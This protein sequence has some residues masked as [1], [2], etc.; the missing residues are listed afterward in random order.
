[1]G[2]GL[3]RAPLVSVLMPV[4]Q[5]ERH[6]AE[7]VASI[8]AQSL[9]DLELLA[10][11]DGSTDASPRILAE[12]AARDARIR[13]LASPHVGL[14]RRLND[15][16]AQARGAFLARMDAD[17]VAHPERLA[18]QVAYLREHAGCVALGTGAL[19]VDP[20]R[21]PIRALPTAESHSEIEARLLAGEGDAL[22]H[23]SAVYRA[24]ALRALGGY[25]EELDGGE[26]LDLHLRLGERGSLA[27]LREILLEYRRSLES[28]SF[29]RR[30]QVRRS[31]EAA[32]ADALRRRGLDPA[33]AQPAWASGERATPEQVFALW[34]NR[35]LEAG[36]R[37]T[38]RR[39][40]QRAFCAAPRR[41]WKLGV[42]A[43]LGLRPFFW[44]RA[45]AA[46]RR[47][48]GRA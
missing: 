17:D 24:E 36:H 39:Y 25:R 46:L 21:R 12:L 9:R 32:L 14:A 29:A 27:N 3:A 4:Y 30:P 26:D 38:A 8:L 2:G 19:E 16:I 23:P 45:R 22:L 11:D 33:G 37:A 13:L 41:H 31:Q 42:R 1:M 44:A 28:V 34:A 43:C 15:G 20:E 35:A 47:A 48:A 18:R 7:A 6:L 40:A 10:L 5:A